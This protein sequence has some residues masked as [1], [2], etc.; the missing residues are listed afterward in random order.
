MTW[1]EALPLIVVA[2]AIL[3]VPGFVFS[4][5]VRVRGLAAVLLAPLF[6]VAMA[7]VLSLVLPIIGIAWS[8]LSYGIGALV[9]A[10]AAFGIKVLLARKWQD[11]LWVPERTSVLVASAVGL[12]G[13]GVLIALQM[14]TAFQ[15]PESISQTYD[16]V[17]HLNAVRWAIDSGDA[18]PLNLGAFTGIS[19]Y[20]SAWHAMASLV[21]MATGASIPVAVSVTN[22]AIGAIVWPLGALY[23]VRQIVGSRLVSTIVALIFIPAFTGFPLMMIDWGVLYP[24]LLSIALLPAGM[25]LVFSAMGLGKGH[26]PATPVAWL[27]VL[28]AVP[29]IAVAHPSTLMAL[30]AFVL[31]AVLLWA[32]GL[33]KNLLPVN[34]PERRRQLWIII[35]A[36][37]VSALVLAIVWRKFRPPPGAAGWGAVESSPQA[38][39]E[40]FLGGAMGRP[41]AA[42]IAVCMVVGLI[43]IFVMRRQLWLLGTFLV[44]GLL[45]F[46]AAG[47]DFSPRWFLTGVWYYDSYRLAA[48]LPVA[49]VGPAVIGATYLWD[50]AHRRIAAVRQRPAGRQEDPGSRTPLRITTYAAGVVV[51]VFATQFGVMTWAVN[52]AHFAYVASPVSGLLS[53]DERALLDRLDTHVEPGA[54]IAGL[55]SSGAALAY[56]ISGREVMQPHIL[57]THGDNVDIVNAGLK[58]AGQFP[59]VCDAVKELDVKYALD[60]GTRTVTGTM[61]GF[62]GL[63]D[64]GSSTSLELIDQQGS[65]AK[66]YKVTAC[67]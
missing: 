31:P 16:N 45:F 65:E 30:L 17:F 3:V 28:V 52:Q 55:P 67:W 54:V 19:A 14:G 27:L 49:M 12:L 62:G 34:T 6:S 8:P 47:L 10:A 46:Y 18:S 48:L 33:V 50:E 57:T 25:G 63:M 24:N 39:G 13:A 1:W 41:A 44:A 58:S 37:V 21:A 51:L 64:L 32:C 40:I 22:L 43:R 11:P 42:I 4:L 26:R 36:A 61:T 9:I 56:A 7:S 38:I 15:T 2:G 35:G 5:A 23:L 20:P 29:A 53:P 59:W 60:F 66:L